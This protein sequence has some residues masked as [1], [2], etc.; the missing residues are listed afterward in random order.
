MMAIPL[1]T[2]AK[3]NLKPSFMVV[4]S[5][6]LQRKFVFDSTDNLAETTT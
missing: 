2:Q 1:L 3:A 6:L 5:G 4:H